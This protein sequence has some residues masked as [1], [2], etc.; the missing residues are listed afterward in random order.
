MKRKIDASNK[1]KKCVIKK[2]LKEDPRGNNKIDVCQVNNEDN[3]RLKSRDEYARGSSTERY[4]SSTGSMSQSNDEK[5]STES[6]DSS[7][8]AKS[9]TTRRRSFWIYCTLN[10]INFLLLAAF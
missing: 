3:I 10:V 6:V 2:V 7:L 1:Y 9:N 4:E 8:S 5:S